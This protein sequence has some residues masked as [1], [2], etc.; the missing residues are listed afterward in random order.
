MYFHTDVCLWTS[1][2]STKDNTDIINTAE[3][4]IFLWNVL[5]HKAWMHLTEY[6]YMPAYV[7]V[8]VCPLCLH[9]EL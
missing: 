1:A 7:C 8:C 5:I 2:S 4:Y 3:D 9:L 6:E